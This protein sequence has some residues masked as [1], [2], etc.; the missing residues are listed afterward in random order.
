MISL[1]Y[2]AQEYIHIKLPLSEFFAPQLV[3]GPIFTLTF[4]R[5]VRNVFVANA[6]FQIDGW[7]QT[8]G[9]IVDGDFLLIV[10]KAVVVERSEESGQKGAILVLLRKVLLL[11]RWAGSW[12]N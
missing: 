9:T 3:Q 6:E 11:R 4:H 10:G 12:W 2:I 8:I 1:L 5:A 7:L